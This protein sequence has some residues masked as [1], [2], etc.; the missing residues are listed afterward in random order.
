MNFQSEHWEQN[1]QTVVMLLDANDN[2]I[3]ELA[4][5]DEYMSHEMTTAQAIIDPG[6]SRK[7]IADEMGMYSDTFNDFRGH[8]S[9]ARRGKEWSFYFANIVRTLK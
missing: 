3:V 5:G 4:M 2:V 6:S 7:W 9:V 8:V 1:G